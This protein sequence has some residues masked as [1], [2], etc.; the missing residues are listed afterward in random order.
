MAKRGLNGVLTKVYGGKDFEATVTKT[1][2]LAP[3]FVRLH[4]SAPEFMECATPDPGAFVRFWFPDPKEPEVEHQRAY[5]FVEANKKEGTFAIDVVLHEPSGPGSFW[6]RQAVEGA[7]VTVSSLG[8]KEAFAAPEVAPKGY[9][10]IGDSAS[11]PAINAILTQLPGDMPVELYLEQH[12]EDDREI[13]LA[14][15]PNC[16]LHWVPRAGEG[17]LAAAIERK[18]WS[19]WHAW[20]ACE[21][22]TIGHLR[23]LLKKDFHLPKPAVHMRAYWYEGRAFGKRR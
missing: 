18:D 17:S 21:S 2:Y 8:G 1:E 22:G 7:V 5:T 14:L 19:G 4:F 15:A 9:L 12:S 11:I 20:A 10:L 3:H 23:A 6:A 16:N 13:P